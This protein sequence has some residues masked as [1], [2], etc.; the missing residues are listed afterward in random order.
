MQAIK[1]FE[2]DSFPNGMQGLCNSQSFMT[3]LGAKADWSP[4]QAKR[5][6]KQALHTCPWDSVHALQ[7]ASAALEANTAAA[8]AF[9]QRISCYCYTQQGVGEDSPVILL[10][11]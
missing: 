10:R 2:A 5:L 11:P 6:A 7:L 3:D 9:A 1:A 4:L 8:A